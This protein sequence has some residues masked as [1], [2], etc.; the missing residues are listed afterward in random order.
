MTTE[1][2][3]SIEGGGFKIFAKCALLT[4]FNNVIG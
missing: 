1:G 4:V 3:L 2:G